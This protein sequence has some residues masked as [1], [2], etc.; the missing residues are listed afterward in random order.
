MSDADLSRA[1]DIPE[2]V[3][4][5][6]EG[7]VPWWGVIMAFLLAG[8]VVGGGAA[9][10][11]ATLGDTFEPWAGGASELGMMAVIL[12]GAVMASALPGFVVIRGLMAWT[13]ARI[14]PGFVLVWILGACGPLWL[15]L[16]TTMFQVV[17]FVVML[18]VAALPVIL[19]ATLHY[20]IERALRRAP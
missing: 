11:M 4:P 8:V 3:R 15:H 17:I 5:A 12:T 6:S 13:G 20:L 14:W 2:P 16:G 19:G 1:F 7:R 9:V 10:I 18:K